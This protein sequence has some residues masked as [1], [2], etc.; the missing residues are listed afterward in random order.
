MFKSKDRKIEVLRNVPLFSACSKQELARIASLTDH[1]EVK[2]GTVLTKEG[3]PGGE[4]FV[5]ASGKAEATLR[6]DKLGVL[7]PGAVVGEM[8]LLDRAPRSATVKAVDDLNVLVL[9]PRSFAAMIDETPTVARK[10]MQALAQR[11]R[12]LED[13]PTY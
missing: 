1:L 8:A 7:G 3:D 4:A 11:V 6:G 5:I 12:E 13:A 2:A 10:I 9:D